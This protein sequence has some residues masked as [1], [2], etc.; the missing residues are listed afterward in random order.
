MVN[1]A[2]LASAAFK[3]TWIWQAIDAWKKIVDVVQ[4]ASKAPSNK[5]ASVVAK[6]S[7][8]P[9][10]DDTK[11]Y[12]DLN[13]TTWIWWYG[14][15]Q[16]VDT[17][18]KGMQVRAYRPDLIKDMYDTQSFEQGM[19]DS[20][21]RSKVAKQK[22]S[23][24]FNNTSSLNLESTLGQINFAKQKAIQ[25][26]QAIQDEASPISKAFKA[27]IGEDKYNAYKDLMGK[28]ESYYTAISS[29]KSLQDSTPS[30]TRSLYNTD[31][32]RWVTN[33]AT[34][35][36]MEPMNLAADQL[37]WEGKI[38]T[39]TF[40]KVKKAAG[41]LVW[42]TPK[43]MALGAVGDYAAT[44]GL[45]NAWYNVW[46]NVGYNMTKLGWAIRNVSQTSPYLYNATI[47]S[48]LT[49]ALD[50]GTQKLAW[51]DYS[52]A[53]VAQ[54]LIMGAALPSVFKWVW[55]VFGK[56]KLSLTPKDVKW[57]SDALQKEVEVNGAASI[58]DAIDNIGDSHVLSDGKTTLKD[59]VDNYKQNTKVNPDATLSHEEVVSWLSKDNISISTPWA[60]RLAN[61]VTDVN[62]K[63]KWDATPTE[64]GYGAMTWDDRIQMFKA[65]VMDKVRS[66]SL[67]TDS[68]VKQII[69]DAAKLHWVD[70]PTYHSTNSPLDTLNDL[71]HNK[72]FSPS[73]LTSAS[74]MEDIVKSIEG[75]VP[76]YTPSHI[77]EIRTMGDINHT[78]APTKISEI[79]KAYDVPVNQDRLIKDGKLQNPYL[80]E[81]A[82]RVEVRMS[83]YNPSKSA[84]L[85]RIKNAI[86]TSKLKLNEGIKKIGT[87]GN[88]QV[89]EVGRIKKSI[90]WTISTSPEFASLNRFTK[91]SIVDSF[92]NRSY[93]TL[94]DVSKN[95]SSLTEKL[96]IATFKQLSTE[97]DAQ[98]KKV[99]KLAASRTRKNG[100]D[101]GYG[102][103][104]AEAYN[105]FKQA[106]ANWDLL[107]M[108][109]IKNK[110][111]TF[112]KE[113]RVVYQ[114]T[115]ANR[116]ATTQNVAYSAVDELDKSWQGRFT[117]R[118][119]NTPE[120]GT[121][122][123][124]TFLQNVWGFFESNIGTHLEI[125]KIFGEDSVLTKIFQKDFTYGQSLQ[126]LKKLTIVDNWLPQLAKSISKDISW[127]AESQ[128]NKWSL[129]RNRNS[130][131]HEYNMVNDMLF[132]KDKNWKYQFKPMYDIG[133]F[134]KK[135]SKLFESG[136]AIHF[137]DNSNPELKE[138]VLKSVYDEFDALYSKGWEF[139]KTENLFREHF[140]ENGLSIKDKMKRLFN[141]NFDLVENYHPIQVQG[142]GWDDVIWDVGELST[143][144]QDSI[145]DGFLNTRVWPWKDLKMVTDPYELLTRHVN[146]SVYW[147]N[148][149]EQLKKA[150]AVYRVLHK[151]RIGVTQDAI[152]K[153]LKAMEVG[154]WEDMKKI[155]DMGIFDWENK[156]DIAD[157]NNAIFSPE[158]DKIIHTHL[159]KIATQGANLGQKIDFGWKA[160]VTR[161]YSHAYRALL[162]G[163]RTP[164]KQLSSLWDTLINWGEK[165][166]ASAT[167]SSL[168]IE[169]RR[170][171]LNSSGY[172]KERQAPV[173]SW[174]WAWKNLQTS[175]HF[176]WTTKAR[177]MY[178]EGMDK[179]FGNAIKLMDWEMSTNAWFTW[180]SK[181]LDEVHPSLH[182]AWR[183]LNLQ[184]IQKKLTPNEWHDAIWSADQ[185][186]SKVMGSNQLLDAGL[187][188]RS[189]MSKWVLFLWKTWLNR[190]VMLWDTVHDIM[191]GK[192]GW[193]EAAVVAT[194][195]VIGT[196]YTYALFKTIDHVYNG[197]MVWLWAK[198]EDQAN[199][200][201]DIMGN[202]VKDPTFGNK[203]TSEMIY[204]IGT[205]LQSPSGWLDLTQ[206][207]APL[208][209][210]I[211]KITSAPTW[212]RKAQE[213]LYALMNTLVHKDN[214]NA[215]RKWLSLVWVWNTNVENAKYDEG[216]KQVI[217][218]YWGET[219]SNIDELVKKQ[220]EI[221]TA[222][223]PLSDMKKQKSDAK[224]SFIT[225]LSKKYW[226]NITKKE[227]ANELQSHPEIVN[228]MKKASDIE[229]LYTQVQ[230]QV[231]KTS[232]QKDS[233]LMGKSVDVIF[234]VEIKPLLDAWDKKAVAKRFQELVEKWILKQESG[235]QKLMKMVVQYKP[236]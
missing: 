140:V 65:E 99:Q 34:G 31:L 152:E 168:S 220:N 190:M 32:L 85:T 18:S 35:G 203:V 73:K 19:V 42:D 47:N 103:Q 162:S 124:K 115:L 149:V 185:F 36:E 5:G 166:F 159:G 214:V 179:V 215:V 228:D 61:V 148:M 66:S 194:N 173:F 62:K 141:K 196:A 232:W 100:I 206:G 50:Y 14:E 3:S 129:W 60:K 161:V 142:K 95:S 172:L 163:W 88:Q 123:P 234:N 198:S 147:N 64:A 204:I 112:E 120:S 169:N 28:A 91:K 155:F 207:I 191:K 199:A 176:A 94:D 8:A 29:D 105:G 170:V 178:E 7:A 51:K 12:Q 71:F 23:S 171:A 217:K 21:I 175:S 205:I 219:P 70:I 30:F 52:W 125:P 109:E 20:T 236:Q 41:T 33:K 193:K 202:K 16:T 158:V 13:V 81:L 6:T 89:K 222:N 157:G 86:D 151:G 11:L 192:Y 136:D 27:N 135:N 137:W 110:L 56:I 113:W 132:V 77:D 208:T 24:L 126:Q 119:A 195:I 130:N 17:I 150:E 211:K 224:A 153:E 229:T 181:H 218:Q 93:S 133:N 37:A 44:E 72:D 221:N 26:V 127:D 15:W 225:W 233:L 92:L 39:S 223:K 182:S 83:G 122:R 45:I 226:V 188:T 139:T 154:D 118:F 121:A 146:W 68:N 108:G 111:K 75:D 22:D 78:E 4:K 114:E 180:L 55:E 164:F 96:H 183:K 230:T 143:F 117:A 2:S 102:M 174:E 197:A 131:A 69:D 101:L 87:V 144:Y 107:A 49:T 134:K 145:Q 227:F 67:I 79:A 46:G 57:I 59:V 201:Y 98:I 9:L 128:L 184:E 63:I 48:W 106:R 84:A 165:N 38:E 10:P 54:S 212:E 138:K 187:G 1:L 76:M 177:L 53:D 58:H 40:S 200:I 43:Y 235:Q 189:V 80:Q 231:A 209:Q 167:R 210:G 74:T 116:K 216:A 97:V 25:D 186:M 156:V 160:I 90:T 213:A 82:N 104:M